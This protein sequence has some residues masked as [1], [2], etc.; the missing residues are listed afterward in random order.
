[1]KNILFTLK[2]D[3][4]LA[5]FIFE[6][7][8][9]LDKKTTQYF[10]PLGTERPKYK[11]VVELAFLAMTPAQLLVFR[12]KVKGNDFVELTLLCKNVEKQSVELLSKMEETTLTRIADKENT[13]TTNSQKKEQ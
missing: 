9:F 3:N 1:M 5:K 11:G 7:G 12:S 8:E 4:I 6:E 2:K 13:P 10:K